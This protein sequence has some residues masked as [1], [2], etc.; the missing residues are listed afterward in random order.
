MPYHRPQCNYAASEDGAISFA[1]SKLPNA[2]RRNKRARRIS[3]AGRF[4]SREEIYLVAI[5]LAVLMVPPDLFRPS[6]AP[7]QYVSAFRAASV[8]SRHSEASER[9][10]AQGSVP[11]KVTRAMPGIVSSNA[12]S[13]DSF[14]R[15]CER[16]CA[17]CRFC[18]AFASRGLANS[19]LSPR[20]PPSNGARALPAAPSAPLRRISPLESARPCEMQFP[21]A[22]SFKQRP[23][24]P[25]PWI[26]CMRERVR[27][28]PA[29]SPPLV[30]QVSA[31]GRTFTNADCKILLPPLVYRV[32]QLVRNLATDNRRDFA[33]PPLQ[34]CPNSKLEPRPSASPATSNRNLRGR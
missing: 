21:P 13:G 3:F 32:Q 25:V 4:G 5:G 8:P 10:T 31:L 11:T 23:R 16:R 29:R 20:L 2:W 14:L 33:R 27:L 18:P 12:T 24:Q 28:L 7:F 26:N 22:A 34:H 17:P 30:N 1:E 6:A 9:V 15:F 19:T